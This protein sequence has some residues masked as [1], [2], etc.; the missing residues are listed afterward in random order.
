MIISCIIPYFNCYVIIILIFNIKL[1]KKNNILNDKKKDT[2][3][4]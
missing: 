3:I 4:L 1:K 2:I